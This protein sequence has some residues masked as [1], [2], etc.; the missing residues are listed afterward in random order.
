MYQSQLPDSREYSE[1]PE[2]NIAAKKTLGFVGRWVSF[3]KKDSSSRWKLCLVSG[4]VSHSPGL[5]KISAVSAVSRRLHAFQCTFRIAR[6]KRDHDSSGAWA[7]R[8]LAFHVLRL[9]GKRKQVH[10]DHEIVME[11]LQEIYWWFVWK[12]HLQS[13][14]E[15]LWFE[16]EDVD[17]GVASMLSSKLWRALCV[18]AMCL[19]EPATKL[20][21]GI[22]VH[23]CLK[24]RLVPP[25]LI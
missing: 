23:H 7:P 13:N 12:L 19:R 17:A 3:C 14:V 24:P 2:T 25:Q 22:I 1:Q 8:A 15:N 16:S 18:V 9:L 5:R 10:E 6:Q 11:I 20:P 4:R 21:K